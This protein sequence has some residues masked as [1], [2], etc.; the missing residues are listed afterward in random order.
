MEIKRLIL[1][2][3]TILIV[4]ISSGSK[5]PATLID[6]FSTAY[7]RSGPG[8]EF[9]II[10]SLL[11]DEFFYYAVDSNSIWAK[12]S[13]WRGI[14]VQGYIDTGSI[15]D[16]VN[17]DQ[18]TQADLIS[19]T[20]DKQKSLAEKLAFAFETNDSSAYALSRS[21]LGQHSDF[22]YNPILDILPQYLSVSQDTVIL[23]LFFTTLLVNS[24]TASEIPSYTIGDCFRRNPILILSQLNKLSG[25][26]QKRFI[27]NSIEWGLLNL[28]YPEEN[29]QAKKDEFI[30]L[31]LQIDQFRKELSN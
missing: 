31:Q 23:N 26:H 4:L 5:G 28:F 8:L 16:I 15:E 27:L 10:D 2:H 25:E 13:I 1:S 29:T 12:I 3:L 21:E 19:R 17:L 30:K 20:L 7:V 9:E 14:Q 24:G 22:K 11:K 6:P 18:E